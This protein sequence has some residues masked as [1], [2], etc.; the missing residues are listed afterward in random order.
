MSLNREASVSSSSLPQTNKSYSSHSLAATSTTSMDKSSALSP[1]FKSKAARQ[2]INEMAGQQNEEPT[3][4]CSI[5]RLI[6][7]EKRRHYTAPDNSLIKSMNHLSTN[8]DEVFPGFESER[9]R[10]RDDLDMERALRQR[11]DTPDVVRSTLSNKEL[12]YNENTIESLLGTPNKISIPE[13]YIP[14]KLPQLSPEEEQH[15]LKKVES[16]KKMLTDTT[17]IPQHK[18]QK[19]KFHL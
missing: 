17:I 16:I 10:A 4:K 3:V 1:V 19:S 2:I 7:K 18:T 5:R 15:R 12:K 9:R 14:E 8:D 6:P 13:R 11:T